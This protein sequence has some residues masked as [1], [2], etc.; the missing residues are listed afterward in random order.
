MAKKLKQR[1]KA[2]SISVYLSESDLKK[3]NDFSEKVGICRNQIMVNCIRSG[4]DDMEVFDRLGGF[5]L[6]T[7]ASDFVKWCRGGRMFNE[8]AV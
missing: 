7:W 8:K 5:R 1:E 2:V 4:L 6:R 3:L